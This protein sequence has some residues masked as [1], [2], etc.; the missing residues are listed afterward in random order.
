MVDYDPFEYGADI[1]A[2]DEPPDHSHEPVPAPEDAEQ[3]DWMLRRIA[4]LRAERDEISALYQAQV[5]QLNAWLHDVTDGLD[6]HIAALDTA[7][8]GWLQAVGKT[9]VKLPHGKV[10][11][12]KGSKS[13][14][15][16]D[17][18][19]L[20]E[21]IEA[22]HPDMIVVERRVAGK[23]QLKSLFVDPP[24]GFGEHA[25]QAPVVTGDGEIVPGVEWST[26]GRSYGAV[27]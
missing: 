14:Q 16:V 20:S 23:T 18:V 12:R 5:E 27:T 21:W 15:I 4:K 8:A 6:A 13:L 24:D 25:D 7:L 10:A 3:A 2:A 22:N 19:A 26:D 1:L 11:S 9:S 17:G